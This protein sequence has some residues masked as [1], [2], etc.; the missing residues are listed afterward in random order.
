M[1]YLMLYGDGRPQPWMIAAD[2]PG[3]RVPTR[4]GGDWQWVA[5]RSEGVRVAVSGD[6]FP[7][8][9]SARD[10]ARRVRQQACTAIGP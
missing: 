5:W 10:A 8:E 7:S 9:E 2:D 4:A 1:T 3:Y 6:W